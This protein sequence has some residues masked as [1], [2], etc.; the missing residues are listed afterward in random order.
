M[1]PNLKAF[2]R[3]TATIVIG[4]ITFVVKELASAA[5]V[6]S[7]KDD[8]DHSYRLAVMCTFNADGVTPAFSDEDIPDM[9]SETSMS[10]MTELYRTV[11]TVNGMD[12]KAEAKNSSAAPSAG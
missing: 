9:K 7:L 5:E 2:S 6:Q 12:I 11:S 4:G 10:S 3:R 8:P 1:N